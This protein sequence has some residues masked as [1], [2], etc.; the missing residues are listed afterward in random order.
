MNGFMAPFSSTA[1]RSSAFS[2]LDARV[3]LIL[4]LVCAVALFANGSWTML[5]C[6]GALLAVCV[7]MSEASPLALLWFGRPILFILLL[8]IV[9]N[10]LRLDGT[11]S[12]TIWGMVGVSPAGALRGAAAA[13]RVLLLLGF[14]LVVSTSTTPTEICDG[15]IRLMRPLARLGVPVEGIGMVLSIALRFIPLVGEEL[16]RIHTAQ[17]S[18]AASF[19]EGALIERIRLWASVLTPLI[20]GLFRRADRLAEAMTA[21]C[22]GSGR[23]RAISRKPLSI[24]DRIVLLMGIAAMIALALLA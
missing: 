1:A 13:L 15:C 24:T 23:V 16:M 19:D 20:V 22:F 2:R 17:R 7:I 6:C 9:A 14:S 4:L 5:L 11:G 18:R 8:T 12:V 21:R 3:K 10:G